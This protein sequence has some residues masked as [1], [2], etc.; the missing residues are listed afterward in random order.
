MSSFS[1]SK[2]KKENQESVANGKAKSEDI[3][4][5]GKEEKG[6][7]ASKAAVDPEPKDSKDIKEAS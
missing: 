3:K 5:P 1:F 2:K 4:S 6:P 7:K